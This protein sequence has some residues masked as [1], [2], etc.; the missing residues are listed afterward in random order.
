MEGHCEIAKR[1]RDRE[2]LVMQITTANGQHPSLT[3]GETDIKISNV[4][5]GTLT[6]NVDTQVKRMATRV[7][8]DTPHPVQTHT[9]PSAG[10]CPNQRTPDIDVHG[11]ERSA[12]PNN[13]ML[14]TLWPC[15]KRGGSA[16]HSSQR[17][18]GC[19]SV[20]VEGAE[21]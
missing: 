18:L 10:Q 16:K 21:V 19:N 7:P 6:S 3:S 1:I 11:M 4:C 15:G 14:V 20:G 9:F 13:R 12:R 2:K 8:D 5:F 17:G